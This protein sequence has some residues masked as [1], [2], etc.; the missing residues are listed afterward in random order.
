MSENVYGTSKASFFSDFRFGNAGDRHNDGRA[1]RKVGG[2]AGSRAGGETGCG[3]DGAA[4][5]LR[6]RMGLY[7]D[8]SE[9]SKEHRRLYQQAGTGREFADQCVSFAGACYRF[10]RIALD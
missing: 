10:L 3:G 4:E 1:A 7:G 8:V 9:R 2:E 5:I 6:G